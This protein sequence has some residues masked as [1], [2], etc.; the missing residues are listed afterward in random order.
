[1]ME[2]KKLLNKYKDIKSKKREKVK[3]NF[4]T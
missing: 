3:K 4:R 2:T 1:M